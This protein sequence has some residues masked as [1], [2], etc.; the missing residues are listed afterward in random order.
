MGEGNEP[1]KGFSWCSG[2]KR[3]TTGII[4]WS[5]IFFH[6]YATT[7]EKIAIFVMDTQG[8]FDNKSTHD[9]NLK[10][11]ALG[12]L[13]SS[14]N[15]LNLMNRIQQDQLEYLQF[16]SEITKFTAL[17]REESTENPFQ[18][19]MIL[20][21][22]WMNYEE[23]EFGVEGG[24]KYLTDVLD[25]ESNNQELKTVRESIKKSFQL[26]RCTLLPFPGSKVAS[27]KDYDG[28]W[29]EMDPIF[30]EELKKLIENLLHP[31]N[32]VLKKIDFRDLK[33][34]DMKDYVKKLFTLYQTDQILK[35]ENILELTV[36]TF[37]NNLVETCIEDYKLAIFRNQELVN[38]GTIPTIHEKSKERALKLYDDERKI[39][40]AEHAQ[41]FKVKLTEK[42]DEIFKDFI[43][44]KMRDLQEIADERAKLQAVLDD[45]RKQKK[46]I[47]KALKRTSDLLKQLEETNSQYQLKLEEN[48]LQ[49]QMLQAR[50]N[51]DNQRLRD[52][53]ERLSE[54]ENERR[55]L[56][57]ELEGERQQRQEVQRNL[58]NTNEQLRN[59]AEI[60]RHYQVMLEDNRRLIQTL[61]TRHNNE[62]RQMQGYE[63]RSNR[64]Q[65][66]KNL[67]MVALG[68]GIGVGIV[69]VAPYCVPIIEAGVANLANTIGNLEI[70][71]SAIAGL[72][73]Q[74]SP[75]IYYW[76]KNWGNNQG[77][78]PFN[79]PNF[80]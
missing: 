42:I 21:R 8:L 47:Q 18:N 34:R 61:E 35:T 76:F 51:E 32:M 52:Y 11:F 3:D 59:L 53:E 36:T 62:I 13:I 4:I 14:I 67:L 16:S 30:K 5:D 41:K 56:R 26:I 49:M 17:K 80:A 54:I 38:I 77:S 69:Y 64:E 10:I 28:R 7:G 71:S 55:E 48:N 73:I 9:N 37:M 31:E 43:G 29:S 20:I 2:T 44:Q 50:Q 70:G 46:E 40:Y 6:T 27:S 39:G 65:L 19:L 25:D 45:E 1:L 79:T 57:V 72:S 12:T 60:H 74:T 22:D 63:I 33:G 23:F 58:E 66:F 68:I 15:V 75:L 24:M 78:A